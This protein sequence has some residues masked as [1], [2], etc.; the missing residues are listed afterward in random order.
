MS[1]LVSMFSAIALMFSAPVGC[2]HAMA[3]ASAQMAEAHGD[4]SHFGGG[5]GRSGDGHDH[6][7]HVAHGHDAHYAHDRHGAGDAG[8][9]ASHEHPGVLAGAGAGVGADPD[10][11]TGCDGGAECA[12]ACVAVPS[13]P[14]FYTDI[15]QAP[16]GRSSLTLSFD[17]LASFSSWAD[18]P[19]PRA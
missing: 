19:P 13:M 12:S 5:D 7:A 8:A 2:P 18:T 3:H 4:G 17:D 14:T 16:V 6:A 9:D 15:S 10:C 11:L 1:F